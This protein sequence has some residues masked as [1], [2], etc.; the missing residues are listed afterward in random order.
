MCIIGLVGCSVDLSV[1]W[2][3]YVFFPFYKFEMI[4]V[5]ALASVW[6]LW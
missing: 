2:L 3:V 6:L 5:C 1:D 4:G